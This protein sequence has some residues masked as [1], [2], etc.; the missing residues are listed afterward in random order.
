MF[1]KEEN[2]NTKKRFLGILLINQSSKG[3]LH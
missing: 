1:V 2:K 3:E